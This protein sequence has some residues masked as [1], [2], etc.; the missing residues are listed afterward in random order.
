MT[1]VTPKG[2]CLPY[3]E[4]ILILSDIIC[5]YIYINTTNHL[6]MEYSYFMQAYNFS[7]KRVKEAI[8]YLRDQGLIETEWRTIH[9][10]NGR[11]INNVLFI[12]P[13]MPKIKEIT[14]Q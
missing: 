11:P 4:A 9:T 14:Y 1:Y 3:I 6:Q 10:G 5:Q 8:D 7:R 2:E 12:R 13:N